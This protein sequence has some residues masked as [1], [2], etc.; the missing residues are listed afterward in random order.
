VGEVTTARRLLEERLIRP[1]RT[2]ADERAV[3]THVVLDVDRRPVPV[4]PGR[5][6][7]AAEHVFAHG[8]CLAL[9]LAVAGS[10]GRPVAAHSM[11]H[12]GAEVL[13]HCYAHLDGTG[14]VLDV[15]GTHD[16]GS[17]R[18]VAER[19]SGERVRTMAPRAAWADFA[20]DL[21]PQDVTLAR[22]FVPGLLGH[23]RGAGRGA[24]AVRRT[25]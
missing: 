3:R 24:H 22:S 11:R 2:D 25:G 15:S 23:P 16:L 10:T 13:R 6:D 8:Q 21:V 1:R 7:A 18:S 12:R 4:V 19:R 5:W 20:G 9:A 14:T 17:V